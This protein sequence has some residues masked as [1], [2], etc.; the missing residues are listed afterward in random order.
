VTRIR[1]VVADLDEYAAASRDRN[2]LHLSDD[3]ARRT[4]FGR[5]VVFGALSATAALGALPLQ[6]GRRLVR[7]AAEFRRPLFADIDYEIEA[8]P[9]GEGR[10]TVRVLDGAQAALRLTATFAA[11]VAD[12]TPARA[13]ARGL[14]SAA[15]DRGPSDLTPGLE[16]DVAYAADPRL[17]EALS[18]RHGLAERGVG[19][20]R[21]A[22]LAACSYL[23]GMELP[24]RRALFS[25][26]SLDFDDAPPTPDAR[27][28]ARVEEQDE[29]FG[30][31]TIR[32]ALALGAATARG[33][34]KAFVRPE[35]VD[36]DPSRLVGLPATDALAGRVALVVG[37][38]RGLGAAVALAIA[39]CGCAVVA[40]YAR[41][42]DQAGALRAHAASA[43]GRIEIA[44]VD[45]TDAAGVA[46]LTE[47]LARRHGRLDLLVLCASPPL[48]AMDESPASAARRDEFVATSLAMVRVPTAAA[49]P[50][51]SDAAGRL[52]VFSSSAV[53]DPPPEWPH[54]VD[55]KRAV[56]ELCRAVAASDPRVSVTILRPPRVLTDLTNTVR[57][58]EGAL[59][60]ESVAASIVRGLVA[61]P[62]GGVRLVETF[63]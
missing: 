25:A 58:S 37:A 6:R 13:E 35:P 61:S 22:A 60:A 54:Y 27:C 42:A 44:R 33:E 15:A 55:A 50:L 43:S 14:R 63:E 30:L 23:V 32:V 41:S 51:L 16:V 45:A 49:L 29:R 59:R 2:P 48:L 47:D 53:R 52:I 28:T 12:E 34:V 3:Y 31:L 4:P 38:S 40:T 18:R 10:W 1:F 39:R 17:V 8:A 7:L 46:A 21:V 5:R 62:P 20:S 19:A 57:G 9:K 56:E 11:G 36:L 26:L 24:G